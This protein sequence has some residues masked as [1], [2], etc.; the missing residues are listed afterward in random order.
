M[1]NAA[2]ART[3]TPAS[4]IQTGGPVV[5]SF[6]AVENG[7]G[8]ARTGVGT[9]AGAVMVVVVVTVTVV[10]ASKAMGATWSVV[11]VAR[12]K[13]VENGR[14]TSV[15]TVAGTLSVKVGVGVSGGFGKGSNGRTTGNVGGVVVD[16]GSSVVCVGTVVDV[17][18]V[19]VAVVVVEVATAV[20]VAA[21][22]VVVVSWATPGGAARSTDMAVVS[23]GRTH[24]RSAVVP[25]TVLRIPA[26]SG[27]GSRRRPSKVADRPHGGTTQSRRTTMRRIMKL[28]AAPLAGAAAMAAVLAGPA[29]I[30]NASG[31][32]NLGDTGQLVAKGAAVLVPIEV[33]CGQ[34]SSP[35]MSSSVIV[36]VHQRTGNH[37]TEG[38][39]SARLVCDG[40][41]QTVEALVTA[42]DT[43]FKPGT[44]LVTANTFICDFFGCETMSDTAEM[45]FRN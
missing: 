12:E 29:A 42:E 22:D 36:A 24:R 19:V 28:A 26:P 25:M 11:V 7:A 37:I 23:A 31:A 40:T 16:D 15:V 14:T 39:G 18:V 33:T 3:P 10:G 5:S 4:T 45:R 43:P 27:S 2:R 9:L 21:G 13:G 44:A 32:M 8:A 17:V 6:A 34:A 38:S 41:A 35:P 1:A 30:A 20:V